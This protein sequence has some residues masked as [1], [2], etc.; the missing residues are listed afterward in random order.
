MLRSILLITVLIIPAYLGNAQAPRRG[1]SLGFGVQ[2]VQPYGEFA[3]VY[4]GYPAGLSGNFTA[5][6]G[7]SPFE[8]GAGFAWNSMGSQ[9][10]DV[11]VF[12]GEDENGTE[13]YEMGT[14]RIRSNNHRYQ[15][16]ARF[17]P[18]VGKIQIYADAVA[19]MES[20]S[21]RTDIQLDNSGYSELLESQV[22]HRDITFSFGWAL[23]A[24]VR[25]AQGIFLEGRFENLDG[26]MARYVDPSTIQVNADNNDL[27]FDLRESQTDKFTYQLGVAVQF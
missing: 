8:V 15:A 17:R 26:G 7:R 18:F 4:D 25:L 1:A 5:P 16:I 12:S 11:S 24:R 19:G 23:G 3:K 22:N 20:F 6:L 2:V 10:E 27:L 21:T 14:M 13:I 9:D